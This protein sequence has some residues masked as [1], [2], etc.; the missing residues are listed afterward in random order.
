MLLIDS[1][2]EWSMLL[3]LFLDDFFSFTADFLIVFFGDFPPVVL[4]IRMPPVGGLNFPVSLVTVDL[5]ILAIPEI[6]SSAL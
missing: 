2:S 3:L 1:T 5:F 6:I 4:S